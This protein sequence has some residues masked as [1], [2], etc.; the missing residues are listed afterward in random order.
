MSNMLDV[1]LINPV[2]S[3]VVLFAKYRSSLFV[4]FCLVML[5]I[6]CLFNTATFASNITKK[7]TL[8]EQQLERWVDEQLAP[9]VVKRLK[10]ASSFANKPLLLV[11]T[12]NDKV[13]PR[14]DRFH[15][16]VKQRLSERLAYHHFN[17]VTPSQNLIPGHHSQFNSPNCEPHNGVRAYLELELKPQ[18]GRKI[19]AKFKFKDAYDQQSVSLPYEYASELKLW[20]YKAKDWQ[21]MSVDEGLRGLRHL[22]F[23]FDQADLLAKYLADN[24]SCL[25][26]FQLGS[27]LKIA[28]QG[29]SMTHPL[30]TVVKNLSAYL[31]E[32]NEVT[33][34]SNI[35]Q[36]NFVITVDEL[37]ID[38]YKGLFQVRAIVEDLRTGELLGGAATSSYMTKK[39][40]VEPEI[41]I[42][43]QSDY[44]ELY[45]VATGP[46]IKSK[47]KP[48]DLKTHR[49]IRK[50]Q[51][52][53][54]NKV[55]ISSADNSHS[56]ALRIEC[57]RYVNGANCDGPFERADKP[58][59]VE[60]AVDGHY[61]GAMV[62]ASM[63]D[64]SGNGYNQITGSC[65]MSADGRCQIKFHSDAGLYKGGFAI[66]ASVY[67]GNAVN[68]VDG[69]HYF[70][71]VYYTK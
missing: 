57:V 16:F 32:N 47:D 49:P 44:D 6:I 59:V 31:A 41:Q 53:G 56:N 12:K 27:S 13:Q 70:R 19:K 11:V 45:R 71:Q 48:K 1:I 63:L 22:P 9:E 10:N 7:A 42:A 26:R 3:R 28:V 20:R 50:V 52:L 14:I 40:G 54:V 51:R 58:W 18:R 55:A 67:Q 61:R 34:Y 62:I 36:A 29:D 39:A 38:Q 4:S 25:M 43:Q 66:E 5:T 21:Q 15:A 68:P 37:S 30:D 2:K 23:S 35:E 24:L 33:M 64:A 60:F 46:A 17:I 65:S 69:E 8:A